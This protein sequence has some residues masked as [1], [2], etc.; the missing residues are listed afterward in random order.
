[1][2]NL[3]TFDEFLNESTGNGPDFKAIERQIFDDLDIKTVTFIDNSKGNYRDV[4]FKF[5]DGKSRK[6]IS[7]ASTGPM[8]SNFGIVKQK[9]T[10]I[11]QKI[12]KVLDKAN[13]YLDQLKIDYPELQKA[14]PSAWP[15]TIIKV[16]DKLAKMIW[17]SPDVIPTYT[18]N[19]DYDSSY[20]TN[21]MIYSVTDIKLN[22]K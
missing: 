11:C 10:D 3:Q 17:F 14:A 12:S 9:E 22:K 20:V 15:Y 1:M 21:W 16:N 2:N 4:T 5:N 13:W 7:Y 8:T 19:S 6:G 18:Y